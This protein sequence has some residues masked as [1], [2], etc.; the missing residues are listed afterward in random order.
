MTGPAIP[1]VK[2]IGVWDTVG[3]LGVPTMK[4]FGITLHTD[5]THE[6]SF[7]NTE[8]AHNVEHAYQAL[9]LDEKRTPFSP[10]VWEWP[11]LVGSDQFYALQE[12]KQTWFPG[13]HTSVGGGY[14]DTSISDITLAWMITQL[15]K[16]LSF[17]KNYVPRQRAQ[18]Q[19]FYESKKAEGVVVRPWAL[20]L[21]KTSDGGVLNTMMGRSV[22]TPGEYHPA[23]PQDPSKFQ[24]RTLINTCEFIH[25]SVRYQIKQ[26][27]PGF[28]SKDNDFVGQG[29]YK[30]DALSKWRFIG[31]D[32]PEQEK[33]TGGEWKG[34]GVWEVERK[35]ELVYIVE[36]K[37][38]EGTAE[39]DLVKG[40]PKGFN[41]VSDVLYTQPFM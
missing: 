30:P 23:D 41:G 37:I 33:I 8:V 22:R 1:K 5:S 40:W 39:M 26:K 10:T 27:G 34:Y 15:S 38:E 16:H 36:E 7:V 29:V 35:G 12:L 3:T 9:A 4:L 21:L 20:G 6:Y 28:S 31:P 13:V 32:D 25:P 11:P 24:K 19:E 2:A 18:N 14:A 17:D